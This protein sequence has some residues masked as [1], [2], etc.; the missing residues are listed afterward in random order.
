[1]TPYMCFYHEATLISLLEAVL[2]HKD[3]VE[4]RFLGGVFLAFL[5]FLAV[6]LPVFS[7]LFVLVSW[8]P[9]R[10]RCSLLLLLVFCCLGG[11]LCGSWFCLPSYRPARRHRTARVSF[12][13]FFLFFFFSWHGASFQRADFVT[14]LLQFRHVGAILCVVV[15]F[16]FGSF[17]FFP[18]RLAVTPCS[19]SPSTVS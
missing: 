13:S 12:F 11:G 18:F 2:Y 1:M 3:A 4:V 19:I 8:G 6:S 17:L 10:G 9:F 5:I 16:V 7:C 15:W 14:C